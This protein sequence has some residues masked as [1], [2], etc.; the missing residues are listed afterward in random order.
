MFSALKTYDGSLPE[1]GQVRVFDGVAYLFTMVE[2]ELTPVPLFDSVTTHD[3]EVNYSRVVMTP[4]TF[5][6][7]K[8]SAI[9]TNSAGTFIVPDEWITVNNGSITLTAD[10]KFY[11]RVSF[12]A[13]TKELAT[14]N[15]DLYQPAIRVILPEPVEIETPEEGDWNNPVVTT[16]YCSLSDHTLHSYSDC[17]ADETDSA[18]SGSHLD[19]FCESLFT[20][21]SST[22]FVPPEVPVEC[23]DPVTTNPNSVA[24]PNNIFLSSEDHCCDESS[25]ETEFHLNPYQAHTIRVLEEYVDPEFSSRI[26]MGVLG[27]EKIASDL[28]YGK[29]YDGVIGW[30]KPEIEFQAEDNF[31]ITLDSANFSSSPNATNRLTM[32][33][34][35][36]DKTIL[37]EDPKDLLAMDYTIFTANIDTD[38]NLEFSFLA[39]FDFTLEDAPFDNYAVVTIKPLEV[40]IERTTTQ[41]HCGP[42]TVEDVII[43]GDNAV[44]EEFNF[45]ELNNIH[46]NDQLSSNFSHAS[47]ELEDDFQNSYIE[48]INLDENTSALMENREVILSRTRLIPLDVG[49]IQI[50]NIPSSVTVED[51]DLVL[52]EERTG[53]ISALLK[54][55]NSIIVF[56]DSKS[57]E[58]LSPMIV[59][60]TYSKFSGAPRNPSNLERAA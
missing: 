39:P 47:I 15:H 27:E 50:P 55:D 38:G 45:S 51:N 46:E 56:D 28:I 18:Y 12:Y 43:F 30:F 21:A 52:V 36:A 11:G 7:S 1:F 44:P 24:F 23:Q 17:F 37:A 20:P 16:E 48:D 8:I 9:I 33:F 2:G 13:K 40:I 57:L 54:S 34:S 5:G 53:R 59:N 25:P 60:L 6:S 22:T 49:S 4:N 14:E 19:G 41:P 32:D 42:A 58:D 3:V 10:D 31:A 35:I 26:A 29:D